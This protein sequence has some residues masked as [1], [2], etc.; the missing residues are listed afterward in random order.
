MI[1]QFK[2]NI[3]V[4]I[5][6]MKEGIS[7]ETAT[8]QKGMTLRS[9]KNKILVMS[10]KGG[11]GKS[12]VAVNIAR[13][14]EKMNFRVGMMDIDIHGPSLEKMLNI[15]DKN[16]MQTPD[17]FMVPIAVNE[18]FYA[19]TIASLL[20]NDS[21]PVIWRG[22]MKSNFINQM[23]DS[24][25]WPELD[26]LVIDCPPGTGDEHLT[27]IQTIGIVTG[28]VIVSTPQEIACVDVKKAINFL[29][30]MS[31]NIFGIVENMSYYECPE[32]KSKIEIFKKGGIE[33]L[34]N[35]FKLPLLGSL[36]IDTAIGESCENGSSIMENTKASKSAEIFKEITAKIVKSIT[37]KQSC[38]QTA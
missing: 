35:E 25:K 8:G 4:I 18:N 14:L 34:T 21:T 15:E 20:E 13:S 27:I 3:K 22:P 37:G 17:G 5:S 33:K 36:P 28:A 24:F 30:Q 38:S 19:A 1:R 10:G 7:M 26:Y 29:N 16:L 9:I 23:F 31:V 6:F 32:C 11:V 12:T 2:K